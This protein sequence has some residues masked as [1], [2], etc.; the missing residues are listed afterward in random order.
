MRYHTL[1]IAM[2]LVL[3]TP[4]FAELKQGIT[5]TEIIQSANSQ[6]CLDLQ[7]VGECYWLDCDEKTCKV[8]VSIKIKHY[9]P[10]TVVSAYSDTGSNPWREV[11]IMS[12]PIAGAEGGG[13]MIKTSK[14]RDNKVRFKNVDV[15][16]HPVV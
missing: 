12:Q 9:I 3:N 10:E 15:V 13:S 6:S 7:A 8:K 16:G 1:T 2:L 14:G 5:T 11:A 4:V